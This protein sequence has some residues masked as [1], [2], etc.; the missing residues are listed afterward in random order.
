[1]KDIL[2]DIIEHTRALEGIDLIR[3]EGTQTQTEV[4]ATADDRSVMITG[5]F[6][7]PNAEFIGT[8]GMP[9]LGKLSTILGFDD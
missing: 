5:L 3:V 4:V 8:F 2:Q 6:K 9:N 1:M 7:T